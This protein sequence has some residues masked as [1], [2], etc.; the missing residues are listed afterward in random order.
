MAQRYRV[1]PSELISVDEP[2]AA[3]CF[4]DACSLWGL[5]VERRVQEAGS[6]I[7]NPSLR[8]MTQQATL[9]GLLRGGKKEVSAPSVKFRDPAE[10]FKK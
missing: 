2:Y 4:D 6:T 3:F 5:H 9:A 1:R 8:Q 7:T 10:R